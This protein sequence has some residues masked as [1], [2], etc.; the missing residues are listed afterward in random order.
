MKKVDLPSGRYV[1]AVSGGVD[2]VVLLDVLSKQKELNLIVAHFDHGIRKDSREDRKFVEKLAQNYG[3]VFEY[4]E[5]KL[6]VDT[7]EARARD[8]RYAFLRTIAHKYKVD[9]IVTAHHQDDLLETIIINLL[10]GTGRKG[11]TSLKETNEIKRP[12]LAKTKQELI[13]YATKAKLTWHEDPTNLQT[14]YLRNWVRH[15]VITKLSESDRK[16]LLSLHEDLSK[17]NPEIDN[18]LAAYVKNEV[19]KLSRQDVVMADHAL[20]K[21][22][23]AGWLRAN[24]LTNYDQKIIERIVVGAKTLQTGKTIPVNSG[25]SVEV[26]DKML[27]L[28]R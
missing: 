4:A 2:S 22:L 12:L 13:E 8:A 25:Y 16:K 20:A 1:V 27:L 10:R 23:I 26:Q 7:S 17:Y 28:K 11:L 21:E 9:A 19:N 6:G 15:N 5:G 14:N 18:L 3:L 24:N